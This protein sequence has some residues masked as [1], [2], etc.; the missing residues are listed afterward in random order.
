MDFRYND[1]Y[2]DDQVYEYSSNSD[3]EFQACEIE[4]YLPLPNTSKGLKQFDVTMSTLQ[5]TLTQ[6]NPPNDLKHISIEEKS[7]EVQQI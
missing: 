7:E 5:N 1:F 6:F 3:H 2:E 4:E